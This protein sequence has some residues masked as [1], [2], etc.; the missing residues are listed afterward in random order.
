MTLRRMIRIPGGLAHYV[1]GTVYVLTQLVTYERRL[2]S[3][4]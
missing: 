1:V 4:R 2:P 3:P